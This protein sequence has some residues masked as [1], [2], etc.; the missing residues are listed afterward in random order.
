MVVEYYAERPTMAIPYADLDQI[1]EYGRH[2]G[3]EYLVADWYTARRLRP[4]L[5]PLREGEEVP[6][7]RLVHELRR[8][9][10]TTQIFA[11]DPVPEVPEEIGPPLGFVGD[12]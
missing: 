7:L 1:I 3:A 5:M 12:G 6:G 11:F 4:Q 8:E 10:R 9:G 2:Y